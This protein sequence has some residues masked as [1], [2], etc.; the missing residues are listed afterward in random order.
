MKRFWW[1][2]FFIPLILEGSEV[3]TSE[4]TLFGHFGKGPIETPVRVDQ[5]RFEEF[6]GSDDLSAWPAEIQAQQFFRNGGVLLEV[7]RLDPSL[8]LLEAIVGKEGRPTPRGLGWM[9]ALSNIGLLLIPEMSQLANVERDQIL[10]QLRPWA[11]ARHFTLVLDPPNSVSSVSAMLDWAQS[12]PDGLY[13]A[14]VYFPRVLVDPA[15][16][17]GGTSAARLTIGA[18]GTAAGRIVLNDATR[19]LW[20]SAAGVNGAIAVEGIELPLDDVERG[21]LNDSHVNVIR[22]LPTIGR[23]LFGARTLD[24]SSVENRYLPVTRTERWLAHHLER[25]LAFAAFE[26]NDAQLWAAMRRH[27]E[28]FLL[29][30][31]YEGAFAGATPSQAFFV[32]CDASTTS[33]EDITNRQVRL[34]FG[35]A[36]TRSQEFRVRVLTVD[37]LEPER[38]AEKVRVYYPLPVEGRITVFYPTKPGFSYTAE[39][40]E[41]L[42][43]DW[44]ALS[45]HLGDRA[46]LRADFKPNGP[47]GFMRVRVEK[48]KLGER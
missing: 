31:L 33:A 17:S 6:F 1:L 10:E 3:P 25:S 22:E 2:F 19:G 37:T 8:P 20:N 35:V 27:V 30:L 18:S 34:M 47:R 24:V 46:W 41:D 4:V 9:E 26:A 36:L 14:T 23:V 43:G 44:T 32:R 12:L 29:P 15:V 40:S 28:A 5:V 11:T 45:T 21:N 16:Y 48:E 38:T 13:F 39:A 42:S 7:V